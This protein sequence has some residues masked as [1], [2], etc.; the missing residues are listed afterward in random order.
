[1]SVKAFQGLSVWALRVEG[2]LGYRFEACLL[3]MF[4]HYTELA[5]PVADLFTGHGLEIPWLRIAS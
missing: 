5:L 4:R 2:G 1:L 3:N